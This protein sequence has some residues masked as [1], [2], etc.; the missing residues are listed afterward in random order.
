[1]GNGEDGNVRIVLS[2]TNGAR[3]VSQETKDKLAYKMDFYGPGGE[4]RSAGISPGA[5]SVTV[6][7]T[8]GNWTVRAEAFLDEALFGTGSAAFTVRNGRTN[9]VII[10][11]YPIQDDTPEP[12]TLIAAYLEEAIADDPAAGT[13]TTNPIPLTVSLDLADTAGNGWADLLGVIAGKDRYVALDLSDCTMAGMEF[14]P[15]DNNTGESK[16][17]SLV[18]PGAA[19]SIKAGTY[20]APVFKNFTNLA[21]IT[22]TN[23]ETIGDFAFSY[24]TALTSVS[25]SEVTTIGDYAFWNC[26]ALTTVSLPEVTTIGGR[27]F[28]YSTLTL[29]TVSLLKAVTIGDEAFYG[30]FLAASVSLPAATSIGN[31]AFSNC[32]ALTTVSLPESLTN[33]GDNPFFGCTALT[34]IT[35]DPGNTVYK[36]SDDK[37]MLLSHDGALISFPS[38]SGA[39]TLD[40]VTS[41]GG[42]AFGLCTSLTTVNLAVA[43]TIGVYA[44]QNCTALTSVTLPEATSIGNYAFQSCTALTSVT[45][46]E[47]T[48]IGYDAFQSC[49]ALTTVSLPE[50]K[51]IGDFVFQSCTALTAVDLPKATRIGQGAIRETG[52]VGLAITL[53]DTVPTLGMDMF[54]YITDPKSVTVKVPNNAAWSGIIGG[55]FTGPEDTGGTYWGE[56]FRGKGWNS[57]GVYASG[58]SS[59]VNAN[60]SLTI[61]ALP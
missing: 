4:R 49:T 11:M 6:F 55:S 54:T 19:I 38:A 60:I 59:S 47:A 42:S 40:S 43:Q 61:E 27:A 18:L 12:M 48:R 32:S 26:H 30:T 13:L 53:G 41:V 15:G 21:G 52:A 23:V 22:G 46:P 34:T 1:V 17:V 44:F 57:G 39:V 16:I 58:G 20:S 8:L 31:W 9:T 33:I 28:A 2:G 24:C 35:V 25:L 5:G 7:L 37:K 14:D 3:A 45:L 56:G 10:Q 29:T 50:A 36:H 51:D